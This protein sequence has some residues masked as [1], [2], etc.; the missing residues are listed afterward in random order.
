M[1]AIPVIM[2]GAGRLGRE[3]T[4]MAPRSLAKGNEY[5]ALAFAG[6]GIVKAETT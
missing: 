5:Y 2:Y 1:T 6:G 4:R 3:V